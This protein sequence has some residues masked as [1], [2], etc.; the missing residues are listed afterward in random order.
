MVNFC[1]QRQCSLLRV[2]NKILML[3][4][5]IKSAFACLAIK[6]LGFGYQNHYNTHV[7]NGVSK[8]L[9]H[10]LIT[11]DLAGK[12]GHTQRACKADGYQC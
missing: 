11:H 9:Q 10:A 2:A 4:P 3:F 12:V 5:E 8:S 7:V 6:H 1:L